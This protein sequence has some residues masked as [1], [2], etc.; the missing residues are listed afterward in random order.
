MGRVPL[1]WWQE[2]LRSAATNAHRVSNR[3]RVG[4]AAS[5]FVG[6]D[7]SLYAWASRSGFSPID[8]VGFSFYPSYDGGGSLSAR[9]HVADRWM[10][11]S[12]KNHVGVLGWRVPR[13]ARRVEPGARAVGHAGVGD[14]S[15]AGQGPDRRER[16]RL[17]RAD[18]PAGAG[19]SRP[20]GARDARTRGRRDGGDRDAVRAQR[21]ITSS[22]STAVTGQC[23]VRVRQ[24]QLHDSE[25]PHASE[26][27]ARPRRFRRR[28]QR[29]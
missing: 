4:V 22:P 2:Y 20:A 19:R 7:S 23:A 1:A 18:R 6:T 17:R 21:R 24:R 14:E 26:R 10:R 12:T 5:A 8:V 9:L 3:V 29:P 13:D 25:E 11:R 27:S 28:V 16:R 15:R